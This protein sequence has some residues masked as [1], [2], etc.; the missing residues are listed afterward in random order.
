MAPNINGELCENNLDDDCDGVED[1]G[2]EALGT[3]CSDGIGAC[4]R[5]G[6]LICRPDGSIACSETRGTSRPELCNGVDD[7]CDGEVDEGF[8]INT[9]CERGLGICRSFGVRRCNVGGTGVECDAATINSQPEVCNNLDDDCDGEVDEDFSLGSSC[10]SGQGVCRQAGQVICGAASTTICSAQALPPNINGELCGN[11]LDDDCDGAV[12]EGFGVLGTCVV[13]MG[14]CARTGIQ[15]CSPDR[16]SVICSEV[17]GPPS[18][19]LCNG[20]DDNCDGLIDYETVGGIPAS[21]CSRA[22]NSS[23]LLL[24]GGSAFSSAGQAAPSCSSVDGPEMAYQMQC[25]PG[26]LA[27]WS[28]C[29]Y[30]ENVDLSLFD[31]GQA[32]LRVTI[33]VVETVTR[34][35]NIWYGPYPNRRQLKIKADPDIPLLP[36]RYVQYFSAS[37]ACTDPQACAPMSPG[38]CVEPTMCPLAPAANGTNFMAT[39]EVILA[40]EDCTVGQAR[41]RVRLISIEQFP[42]DC[43]CLSDSNCTADRSCERIP[44]DLLASPICGGA[45]PCAGLCVAT[46]CP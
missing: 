29:R 42:A 25:A 45:L 36:A 43:T 41:G 37:E 17:A 6:T 1:E 11:N 5:T 7:D 21:A 31:L 26:S 33:D 16:R 23:T 4:A 2:D 34:G 38:I 13:G 19:E 35:L 20:L 8:D 30:I 32:H 27:P 46:G 39:A 15:I 18:P 24:G 12:D 14:A 10:F 44:G 22:C 3:A 40:A 9:P 28:V